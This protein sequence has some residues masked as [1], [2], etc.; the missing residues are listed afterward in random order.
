MSEDV[1]IS[2]VVRTLDAARTLGAVL[3]GLKLRGDDELIVVDSGST[4]QTLQIARQAG[5]RIIEMPPG[6]FSYGRSLNLGFAAA[7]NPWILSLSSHCIPMP[8]RSDH[9]Q[10]FRDAVSQY[11]AMF[12]AA[13]GPFHNS[14]VDRLLL[15]GVTFYRLEDYSLGFGIPAGN[16]NCLYSRAC[17]QEH[18]FDEELDMG[19]DCEWYVWALKRGYSLAAVHAASARYASAR[20]MSALYRKG[21]L[22]RRFA[23]RVMTVPKTRAIEV[24]I[25]AVRLGAYW[26]MRRISW[27]TAR[28]GVAYK[29]GAWIE[30][31]NE[32]RDRDR[33]LEK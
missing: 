16:P 12:A 4:D 22:E 15:G 10:L 19:E 32:D 20:P 8:V 21:R 3:E 27:P 11:P 18:P 31:R 2:V 26:L 9:L 1:P 25:Q 23:R 7:L 14:E 5:A 30:S 29:V 17:W 6:S 33:E 28:N 13:V 24:G